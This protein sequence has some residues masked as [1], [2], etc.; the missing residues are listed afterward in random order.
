MKIFTRTSNN[1]RSHASDERGIVIPVWAWPCKK[2]YQIN[3]DE[4]VSGIKVWCI[5]LGIS[6]Y[7]AEGLKFGGSLYFRLSFGPI[8][9]RY[10]VIE[11]SNSVAQ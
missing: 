5:F 9:T 1:W 3:I 6:W 10:R 11:S 4:F 7:R 2:S 8:M